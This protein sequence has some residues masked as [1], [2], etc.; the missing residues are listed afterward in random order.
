MDKPIMLTE[1]P[2]FW[3]QSWRRA[4]EC[5]PVNRRFRFA[6]EDEIAEWNQRAE[7]Y[8]RKSKGE[9]SQSQRE[10]IL[11]WLTSAGAIEKDFT[12]LDIGAG[13]GSFAV[14]LASRLRE[15][16]VLE[17]AREMIMT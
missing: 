10:S 3:K 14:P 16:W 2:E 12:A 9:A 11:E 8:A 17:P 6:A 13:P 5:S 4:K 15:I 1:D 7:A